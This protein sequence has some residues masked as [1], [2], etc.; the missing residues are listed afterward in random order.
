MSKTAILL[1]SMNKPTGYIYF[2]S[3]WFFI[4]VASSGIKAFAGSCRPYTMFLLNV[5]FVLI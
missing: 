2:L 1:L 5:I 4:L 3:F